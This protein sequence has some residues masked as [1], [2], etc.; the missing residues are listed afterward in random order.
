MPPTLTCD[1]SRGTS[2]L[3]ILFFFDSRLRSATLALFFMHPFHPCADFLLCVWYLVSTA[4]GTWTVVFLILPRDARQLVVIVQ[5]QL[6]PIH[7][8]FLP[9]SFQCLQLCNSS[10]YNINNLIWSKTMRFELPRM[11]DKLTVI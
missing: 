10:F 2:D 5:L 11:F 4:L 8:A 1:S 6:A 3:I 9:I 7:Q